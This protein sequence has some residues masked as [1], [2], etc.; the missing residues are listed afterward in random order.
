MRLRSLLGVGLCLPLAGQQA[1][2]RFDAPL[3]EFD[4]LSSVQT[5]GDFDGDGDLDGLGWWWQQYWPGPIRVKGWRNDGRGHFDPMFSFDVSVPTTLYWALD[6]GNFDGNARTD[7]VTWFDSVV[8]VYTMTAAGTPSLVWQLNVSGISPRPN[9]PQALAVADFDGDGLDDLALCTD[10]VRVLLNRGSSFQEIGQIP[11]SLSTL[12]VIDLDGNGRPDLVR[13]DWANNLT[14]IYVSPTGITAG[15]LIQI[16]LPGS[17]EGMT[18]CGDID[19]DGDVDLVSFNM[20]GQYRVLRR[21]G[22]ATF[23]LEA[24]ASG[25]PATGLADVDGDG[26]L[27][28]VCCGG[29][30][31]PQYNTYPSLFEVALNDG[32]GRFQAAWSIPHVGSQ[33]LAG[34]VDIDGDGDTDLVAGR[35]IYFNRDSFRQA[36]QP[37]HGIPQLDSVSAMTDLDDDG[38]PDLPRGSAL[39]PTAQYRND[40]RGVL[41]GHASRLPAFPPGDVCWGPGWRGDLTGD[42][43]DDLIVGYFSNAAFGGMRL[44]VNKSNGDFGDGGFAAAGENFNAGGYL[45][46]FGPDGVVADLD[47]D[48]D[49]DFA[50]GQ[51]DALWLNQGN[52]T[53]VRGV[54]FA[55]GSVHHAADFDRDGRPDLITRNNTAIHLHFG[56][57]DGTFQPPLTFATTSSGFGSIAVG[58]FDGDGDL[59]F[60][61]GSEANGVPELY[62]NAGGRQFN[63]SFLIQLRFNTNGARQ[64]RTADV[65]GDGR[66]DLLYWP[67]L[68]THTGMALSRGDGRGGF[69]APE[70][71]AIDPRAFA[72]VDGDGDLDVFT[73]ERLIAG[74]RFFGADAGLRRQFGTA[75]Q[76]AGGHVPGFGATGPFRAGE[77]LTLRLTGTPGGTL[78]SLVFAL[79]AQQTLDWP[80]PGM[81]AYAYP[82]LLALPFPTSG[83]FGTPGTGRMQVTFAV[84]A[85]VAG[86]TFYHQ[87][88]VYDPSL[89]IPLN[90]T[91]G[92]ELRYGR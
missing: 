80:F 13:Q 35:G 15:A 22:A 25:G 41:T 52:G 24:L 34:A 64:V 92:L 79:S 56:N 60:I 61:A 67:P 31:S 26:D 36:P 83:A 9:V 4:A 85:S 68:G 65:D 88:H 43:L 66:L 87:V 89:A 84:P 37:R 81:V 8:S 28:G 16:G 57:G 82:M 90:Y 75:G 39:Y 40:G 51:A 48:G 71:F 2:A 17:Q 55:W 74:T 91:A 46:S 7:F 50:S 63:V 44:L 59:D 38:D 30:Q 78:V 62:A 42:G 21:T 53:F 33:R 29:G 12:H 32:T 14:P 18:A 27:D 70:L 72:D 6:R 5:L 20:R 58:D 1:N 86:A 3:L 77:Q 69:A 49:R 10:V 23:Q 76:G 47:G 73:A 19:G 11:S 45:G 54:A